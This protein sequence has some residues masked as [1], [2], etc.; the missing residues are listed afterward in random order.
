MVSLTER[1]TQWKSQIGEAERKFAEQTER[2]ASAET[3]L[4]QQEQEFRQQTQEE[5]LTLERQFSFAEAVGIG[6]V[7]QRF[8]EIRRQKTIARKETLPKFARARQEIQTAKAQIASKRSEL[9]SFEK[10]VADIEAF[11]RGRQIGLSGRL[12][13]PLSR[14][15]KKG[16]FSGIGSRKAFEQERKLREIGKPLFDG[17]Q[18]TGFIIGEKGQEQSVALS[19]LDQPSLTKLE[20]AGVIKFQTKDEALLGA[21][22]LGKSFTGQ[23]VLFVTGRRG[24]DVVPVSEFRVKQELLDIKTDTG[25]GDLLD[26]VKRTVTKTERQRDEDI[27]SKCNRHWKG[28]GFNYNNYK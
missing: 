21:T 23:D 28:F 24:V 9:A 17:G 18:L 16:F 2:V 22:D 12:R 20:S 6:G 7:Q 14:E 27:L 3:G 25:T 10:Q 1:I 11:E 4:S 19:A 8:K 15:E 13:R 5:P 26:S